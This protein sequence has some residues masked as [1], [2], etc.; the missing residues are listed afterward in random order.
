MMLV[1][2]GL[3]RASQRLDVEINLLAS[4]RPLKDRARVHLHAYTAETV[5]E[6]VL[7]GRP[8]SLASARAR[9][10]GQKRS[11]APAKADW[12]NSASPNPWRCFRPTAL[13][14]ASFPRWSPSPE[15]PCSTSL[16]RRA[17][18]VPPNTPHSCV[19]CKVF[20]RKNCWPHA[21][22]GARPVDCR[23]PMPW[24]KPAGCPCSSRRS[25][26]PSSKPNKSSNSAKPSSPP[27]H[28]RARAPSC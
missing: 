8:G 25:S 3:F 28:S 10:L 13:S 7:I 11:C 14:C 27:I 24:P 21:S 19:A 6:V 5:A 1:P 22:C 23:S 16:R 9:V 26:R 2:T 4:A 18:S 20:Q 17:A 12:L 15:A